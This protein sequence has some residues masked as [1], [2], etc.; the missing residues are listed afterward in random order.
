MNDSN[1]LFPWVCIEAVGERASASLLFED[2]IKFHISSGIVEKNIKHSVGLLPLIKKLLIQRSLSFLNIKGLILLNGPGSFTGLR[3]AN[4]LVHGIS[5]GL[6]CPVISFSMFELFTFI[7]IVN[8]FELIKKKSSFTIEIVF[9]ARIGEYYQQNLF[10]E[11]LKIKNE[12]NPVV[13]NFLNWLISPISDPQIISHKDLKVNNNCITRLHCPLISDFNLPTFNN[14]EYHGMGINTLSGWTGLFA[15]ANKKNLWCNPLTIQPLYVK[16]KV[17]QTI[18]ERK[19]YS[20]LFLTDITD[21]DIPIISILEKEA[22]SFGWSSINFKDSIKA[23]YVCKKLINNGI[24]VGY[25]IW[26][27]VD[28]ECLLLNFTIAVNRQRKGLGKWMLTRLLHSLS[29]KNLNSIYLEVRPSNKM[30]INL[31]AKNG[32]EIIGRRKNYYPNF[33]SR[34]DALVMR[35]IIL[36]K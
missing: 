5:S 34:E 13:L 27:T 19:Y 20:A 29:E 4:S 30:A 32:F 1:P 35:R 21:E 28:E 25:F 23:G 3:I 7:W 11:R 6:G 33:T 24:I 16:D 12:K 18:D 8:N 22:Y 17:A 10:C 15:L 31:Y 36:K 9:D 26:M 14:L 2:E